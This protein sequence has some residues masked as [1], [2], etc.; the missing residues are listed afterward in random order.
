MNAVSRISACIKQMIGLKLYTRFTT[1]SHSIWSIFTNINILNLLLG[2]CC[3][4]TK[5]LNACM[6]FSLHYSLILITYWIRSCCT[7]MTDDTVAI[8]SVLWTLHCGHCMKQCHFII[9]GD[10]HCSSL[11][12]QGN[13]YHYKLPAVSNWSIA[14]CRQIIWWFSWR[15]AW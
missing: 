7:L 6:H 8:Y 1:L 3:P 2:Q 12:F 10:W 11:H 13:W 9:T 4:H 15:S 5:C 14:N